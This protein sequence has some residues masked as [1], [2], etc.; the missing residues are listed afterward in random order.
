MN[1]L[2]FDTYILSTLPRLNS[3]AASDKFNWVKT[4]FSG[5]AFKRLIHSHHK[6][7]NRGDFLIDDRTH[8]GAGEFGCELIQFGTEK[9]PDWKTIT[10]YLLRK[11]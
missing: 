7:L 1:I 11:Y 9:F 6:H 2:H 4:H 3:S 5:P 8:N 10:S